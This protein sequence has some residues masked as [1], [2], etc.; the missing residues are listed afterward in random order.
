MAVKVPKARIY[1]LGRGEGG[2]Y[3]FSPAYEI[4]GTVGSGGRQ[5]TEGHEPAGPPEADGGAPP[6]RPTHRVRSVA[7]VRGERGGV[8]KVQGE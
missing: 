8:S 6:E 7:D 1:S 4:A 2:G 3:P 5:G